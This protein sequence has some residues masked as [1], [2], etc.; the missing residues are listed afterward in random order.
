MEY[1]ACGYPLVHVSR[2]GRELHPICGGEGPC[3]VQWRFTSCLKCL[4]YA[5]T[6]DPRIEAL[7][8]ELLERDR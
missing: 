1:D 3:A 6:D 4:E 2:P 7:R 8:L 5:P